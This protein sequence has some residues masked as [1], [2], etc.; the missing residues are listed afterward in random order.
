MR[1]IQEGVVRAFGIE[2]QPEPVFVGF[3]ESRQMVE[4]LAASA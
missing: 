1:C 4:P 2:L 3:S